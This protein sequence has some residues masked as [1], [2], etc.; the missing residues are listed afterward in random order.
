MPRFVD[1][2]GK[3]GLG[4]ERGGDDLDLLAGVSGHVQVHRVVGDRFEVELVDVEVAGG[5]GVFHGE[6]DGDELV[7]TRSAPR[8][9]PW[10]LEWSEPGMYW[11]Y[12]MFCGPKGC[13]GRP[14]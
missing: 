12:S 9:L 8:C 4:T 14:W 1:A 6:G 3:A 11:V 2:E 5:G 13:A 7:A 10:S